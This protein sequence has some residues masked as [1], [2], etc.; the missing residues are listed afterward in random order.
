[1]QQPS[2]I[3]EYLE[4]VRQQ[5]RWKK[6]QLPVLEEINNHIIDQKNAFISEGLSEEEAADRAIAEMGDP[7]VVGEQLDRAHRPRPDW[8]LLVMTAAILLLGL[9]IQVLIGPNHRN[10]GAEMFQKQ[11]I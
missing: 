4:T 8:P 9:A 5:I 2:K 10:N 3:T 11:F 1:M 6:A 7:V